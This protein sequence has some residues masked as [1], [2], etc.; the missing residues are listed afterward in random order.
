MQH[1]FYY[2]LVFLDSSIKDTVVIEGHCDWTHP[3]ILLLK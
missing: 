1:L 2:H 3:S